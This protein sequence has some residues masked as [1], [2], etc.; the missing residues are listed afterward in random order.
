MTTT[1]RPHD[2]GNGNPCAP[3]RRTS[4]EMEAARALLRSGRTERD[5]AI[6]A[7]ALGLA[8]ALESAPEPAEPADIVV[9]RSSRT[10]ERI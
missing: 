1:D 5:D 4:A 7:A 2:G 6:E 10:P 8:A 3:N 9:K